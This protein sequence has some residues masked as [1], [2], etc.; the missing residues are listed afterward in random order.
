[1]TAA[2]DR[3][4]VVALPGAEEQ[5]VLLPP[6]EYLGVYSR[7]RA[8]RIFRTAKVAVLFRLAE[9]PGIVLARWYRVQ[10]FRGGR[11]RAGAHSDLVRELSAVLGRR[12]RADRV[13][14]ASFGDCVV[15][16]EVCTVTRDHEQRELAEPNRYS[17]IARVVGRA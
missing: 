7:H 3:S 14:V 16:V 1:M 6:G 12:V 15:R 10:D 17:I 11:I 4:N 8:L 5:I 2:P 9:H 13:P